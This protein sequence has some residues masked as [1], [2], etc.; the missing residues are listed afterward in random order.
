MGATPRY[1]PELAAGLRVPSDAHVSPDGR[2]VAFVVAPVGHEETMPTSAIW[3]ADV[4]AA[5]PPRPFTAGRAEDKMPRWSP[6]GAR[7]AFLSDRAERGTA[8]LHLIEAGGGE[9]HSLTSLPRGLDLI[10]WLPDGASLTGTADRR[11]LAGEQ[12]PGTGIRVASQSARPRVIVRVPLEGG[13][14]S[15]IGPAEGHVWTYAC[16]ADGRRVAALTTPTDDL[17]ETAGDVRLVLIDVTTRAERVLATLKGLPAMIQ[18]SSDGARLVAVGDLPGDPDDT[19]VLLIDASS[20]ELSALDAGQTTPLWAAWQPGLAP[21]LVTLAQDGLANRLDLVDLASGTTRRLEIAPANGSVLPPLS[22]SADGHVL[23]ATRAEPGAPTEVWAGPL[24][25][26]LR[27]LTHLNPELDG[28]ALAPMEPVEWTASDGLT[29][30]GWL[31]RPPGAAE[32]KS[33]PLVVQVHGGPTARWGAAFQGTWHDWGQVLAGAGYAVLLPN[34]RGSTGRGA[35]FTAANRSDL[36]GMDFEDVMRG[37]DAMVE[38]GIADPDRLAVAGWSYGGFMTSW[39]ITRTDRFKAAV[40]G[41][42]VTNWPSKVGTTDIRPMNE[43]RFPGAL[44]ETPDAFWERSPVRYLGRITTP[45]LVVHGDADP[46]VP[47]SQ[48]REFYLGLRA[49]NVPAEFVT[50]PR[51]KHAFH[52]RAYQLDLLQRIVAWLEQWVP[53]DA[54]E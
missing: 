2:R 15:V 25:G 51:Q 32:G 41:A 20:G 9:S 45:T 8:Q 18:W 43:K 29:I 17:A 50:Y 36:G 14:P 24:D 10:S 49:N 27:C 6:D 12:D 19:R 47:V 30:Q 34:P 7:L 42:A 3:M 31:L 44:H 53:T 37:V 28:V 54:T 52:E 23:A 26:E 16:G 22:L 5:T 38:R 11:A 1:T 48:G 4:S 21:R 33:L 39:T 13:E 35:A 46:R 40:A